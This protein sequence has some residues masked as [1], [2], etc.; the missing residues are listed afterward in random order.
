MNNQNNENIIII[1]CPRSG[2]T[3][4]ANMLMKN[5]SS[6]HNISLDSLTM[7]IKRTMPE[8]GIKENSKLKIISEKIVP[9]IANYLHCYKCDY[10]DKKYLIEGLQIN[11]DHLMKESFF[12]DATV[13]CLGFPNAKIDEIF[14][15][16]RK[17]D[18]KLSF[19]YTKKMSDNEL[20]ERISFY[21]R[22]SRFLQSKCNEYKIPFYETDKNR[23]QILKEIFKTLTKNFEIN[24]EIEI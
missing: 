1:G 9:F 23:E 14:N 20:K 5:D 4:L 8:T 12:N 11:P 13:I 24:N 7:A 17:E 15:N 21:I 18:E 22:Y 2:K 10:P 19:S 3:T 6:Y 16:I